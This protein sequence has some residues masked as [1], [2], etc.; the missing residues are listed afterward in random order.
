M[1]YLTALVCLMTFFSKLPIAECTENGISL[2]SP[3]DRSDWEAQREFFKKNG[4]LWIKNFFSREQ[5]LLVRTWAEAINRECQ[6]LLSFMHSV[7]RPIE[8]FPQLMPNSL[9]V[10]PEAKNPHQVCRA[11]DMLSCY[12]DLFHFVAGNI[13][14][15]IGYL[16]G[17]PYVLFKD[18]LN[19]KWPGGGAFLPHQDFPAYDFFGPREHVTAMVTIDKATIENGCLYIARDWIGTFAN[20]PNLDRQALAQGRAILPYI[21]GGGS[22]GSIR[23]DY[24]EKISWIALET[25]PE[26]LV[27]FNSYLPHYSEPNKS[28]FSRR[29]MFLTHNRLREG[30]HRGA[31]YHAKRQDPHNPAFHFATPTNARSK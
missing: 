31:Y 23:P 22:H 7:N 20:D 29:A 11:E 28:Q 6:T 8:L 25:S 4:Y 3:S 15:Y 5:S 10:V 30:D 27:L 12:P 14:S 24:A 13:T 17:E 9:I 16:L 26:D 19:F 2:L 21:E 18:K 1:K